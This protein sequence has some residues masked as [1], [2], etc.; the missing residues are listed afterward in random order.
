[1]RKSIKARTAIPPTTPPA[2]AP[3]FGF[4]ADPSAAGV[5]VDVSVSVADDDEFVEDA[6]RSILL[7]EM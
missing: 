3:T 2:I 1:M 4:F 6:K 7:Q 5:E